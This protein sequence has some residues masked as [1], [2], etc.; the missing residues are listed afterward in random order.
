[1]FLRRV[2]VEKKKNLLRKMKKKKKKKKHKQNWQ[3]ADGFYVQRM[4]NAPCQKSK[5]KFPVKYA[6]SRL[7]IE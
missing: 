4:H 6:K 1:M 2:C 3:G 5:V 7:S